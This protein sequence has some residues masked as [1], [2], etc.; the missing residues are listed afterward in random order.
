MSGPKFITEARAQ[1]PGLKVVFMS[2]FTAEVIGDNAP[3]GQ[4]DVLLNKPFK[5][6]DLAAALHKALNSP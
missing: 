2:G 3:L 6:H 1:R 5:M 4:G